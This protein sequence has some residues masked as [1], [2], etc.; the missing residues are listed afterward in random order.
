MPES[1]K[2]WG[3][4]EKSIEKREAQRSSIKGVFVRTP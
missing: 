4:G 1:L 2:L 3:K